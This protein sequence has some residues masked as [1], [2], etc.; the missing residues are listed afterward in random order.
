MKTFKPH[1]L[2]LGS[3]GSRARSA[4]LQPAVDFDISLASYCFHVDFFTF[5]LVLFLFS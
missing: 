5:H 3:P 1:V 2:A 4:G